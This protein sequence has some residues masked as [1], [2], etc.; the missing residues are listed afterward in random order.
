MAKTKRSLLG[1]SGTIGGMTHVQSSTY[2]EHVRLPRGTIKPAPVNNVLAQN[3]ARAGK[4]T[5]VARQVHHCFKEMGKAF[6]Q[7]QLWQVIMKRMFAAKT[8]SVHEL[9]LSLEGLELN[10]SY[11]L[12]K[13]LGTLPPVKVTSK[14]NRVNVQIAPLPRPHFPGSV[15]CDSYRFELF[16]TWIDGKCIR[17]EGDVANSRWLGLEKEAG[18][19]SFNFSKAKWVK[20]MM[21][22]LKI[23]GGF[24]GEPDSR[25]AVTA[26]RVV[27]VVG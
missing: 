9:L 13:I 4:V 22:I 8:T 27:K 6:T 11:P 10:N 19:V 25:F 2:G 23:G 12:E 1:L 14:N 7:R 26:M 18:K 15:S 3:A 5:A 24:K 20:Y 21:I 17:L 16:I